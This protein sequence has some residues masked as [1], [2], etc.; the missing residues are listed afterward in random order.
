MS[1]SRD[2]ALVTTALHMALGRRV[3][4][5][6]LMHYTDQGSQYTAADYLA[7]LTANGITVSMSRKGDPYG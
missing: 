4:G 7:L 2:E 5:N 6:D 1:A 3:V